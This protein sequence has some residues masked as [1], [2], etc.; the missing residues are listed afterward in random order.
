MKNRSSIQR[1][2]AAFEPGSR[3]VF[4][5]QIVQIDGIVSGST[6]SVRTE[7]TG[8][9][10]LVPIAA[11]KP[12][13]ATEPTRD[14]QSISP[15]E[16]QRILAIADDVRQLA[17]FP[18]NPGELLRQIAAKHYISVRQ[19]QRLSARFRTNPR[20]SALA[21]E[22]RGRPNA[23]YLLSPAVEA[24]VSHVIQKY[25]LRRE[26]H[27]ESEIVERVRSICRRLNYPPP[28]RGAVRRR[29][30]SGQSYDT[31]LRRLGG[32]QARQRW[33]P[34]VGQLCVDTPLALVQIDHTR[35]DA[36]VLSDDRVEVLG[37]PWL[38]VAMDVKTR[39][40]LGFY[41]SMDAPSSVAVGLCIAHAV[42]PKP[43]DAREPGLWPMFGKMK[44][45]LVD[46]GRDLISDAIR[47]GCEEHGITLRTRPLGEPHYGGHIERL[48]GTLMRLAHAVPGTTFSN[49]KSKRD[50][51]SER[52]ATM[53]L[54]EMHAW[55]VQA[56]SRV[57]HVRA[58]R[59][60]GVPP[61]VAWERAWRTDSGE[62]FLPPVVARPEEFRLAF[63][64]FVM[65]RLQR[66][67]IQF[68]QSRYWAESLTCWMHPEQV[69]QVHYDPREFSRTWV[70]TPDHRTIEALAIAGPAAGQPRLAKLNE[71]E[72]ERIDALRDA[73]F[74]ATARLERMAASATRAEKRRLTTKPKVSK[75]ERPG[76]VVT[77]IGGG[78]AVVPL[79]RSSVTIKRLP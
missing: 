34:R 9:I 20:T 38:T 56:I 13:P 40:V 32:K 8:V 29:I 64:P 30:E 58:H 26:R 11:L 75:R 71:A 25:F 41:L 76:N 70:R 27:S 28:S 18:R 65:R 39:V 36:M 44:E 53:T 1:E 48:I 57:Y 69:V 77:G 67:G 74:E 4:D 47:R 22:K 23:S 61:L 17:E 73:G 31:D 51:P 19:V 55:L 37:R 45:I 50:Y 43:E 66:S 35:L 49:V 14:V 54:W 72:R 78:N 5:K 42:L 10:S 15:V 63:L 52:K 2:H 7:A 3:W 33:K 6:V 60:L 59:M 21:K 46:N 16:W 62:V 24:V 12:L 79:A 68:K